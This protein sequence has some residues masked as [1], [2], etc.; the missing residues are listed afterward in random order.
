MSFSKAVR[1]NFTSVR[2]SVF[3]FVFNET[4]KINA[5]GFHLPAT[6][7]K[8]IINNNYIEIAIC[9]YLLAR[10]LVRV[11]FTVFLKCLRDKLIDLLLVI[12]MKG[13]VSRHINL[14]SASCKE[15]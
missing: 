9:F 10:I 14:L 12:N 1:Q 4:V 7:Q 13:N 5:N 6:T 3:Q 8:G 11:K 2:R 15:Q